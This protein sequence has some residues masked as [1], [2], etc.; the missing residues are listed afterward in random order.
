MNPIKRLDEL[1]KLMDLGVLSRE[2]FEREKD[3]LRSL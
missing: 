3:K 2:E 1:E